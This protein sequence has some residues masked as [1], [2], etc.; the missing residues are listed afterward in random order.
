MYKITIFLTT[1]AT[2]DFIGVHKPELQKSNWHYYEEADG[3]MLHFRKEH[4]VMVK[5]VTIL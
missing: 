4:M 2:Y 5:E 3:T 1:G